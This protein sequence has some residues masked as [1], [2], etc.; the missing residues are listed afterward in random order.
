MA[1]AALDF[2]AAC[3]L[4]IL[5]HYEHSRSVQPSV[6][7]NVYLLLSLIF[8]V[9]R[10]RTL[11]LIPG[12]VVRNLAVI[13][14]MS[15]GIKLGI[16]ILEAQEK[17]GILLEVYKDLPPEATSGIYKRSVFW[18]L[19]PLF[20]SGFA[21]ILRM[22]DLDSIDDNLSSSAMHKHFWAA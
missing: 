21:K 13:T 6:L 12:P 4:C 18:W 19:N 15:V 20:R 5:S 22:G 10:T 17:R 2:A 1:A 7:I 16:L 3:G 9:V 8:D 14:S 11:W